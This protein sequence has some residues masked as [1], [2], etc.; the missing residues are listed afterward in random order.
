MNHVSFRVLSAFVMS[1]ILATP[2]WADSY[3]CSMH[4]H[5]VRHASGQCPICRMNLEAH[6][7]SAHDHGLAERSVVYTSEAHM[8]LSGIRTATAK[9]MALKSKIVT[10]GRVSLDPV[11]YMAVEEY[12]EAVRRAELARTADHK[13]MEQGEMAMHQAAAKL[14]VLGVTREQVERLLAGKID[15]WSFVAPVGSVWVLASV[16]QTQL[17]RLS[18]GQQAVVSLPEDPARTVPATVARLN[19]QYEPEAGVFKVRLELPDREGRFI[20]DMLVD[21]RFDLVLPEAIVIPEDAVVE[22]GARSVVF[23]VEGSSIVPRIVVAGDRGEGQVI[24]REGISEGERVVAHAT[25]LVD[26]ESQ[27]RAMSALP[28]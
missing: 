9:R 20:P 17:R 7:E 5:V 4:P 14:R 15:E 3:R 21:V 8:R 26:S 18:I 23:V 28:Q 11:T 25:F 1:F 13:T 12:M 19:P 2:T 16:S 22:T 6:D 27:I 10:A 24:I